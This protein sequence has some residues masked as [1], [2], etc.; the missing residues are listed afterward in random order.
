MRSNNR[1]QYRVFSMSRGMWLWNEEEHPGG[2]S[3]VGDRMKPTPVAV[4]L[5]QYTVIRPEGVRCFAF[6]IGTPVFPTFNPTE[7]NFPMDE[8]RASYSVVSSFPPDVP[9]VTILFNLQRPPIHP[10][11]LGAWYYL[12]PC[13]TDLA[14]EWYFSPGARGQQNETPV[15]WFFLG[16]SFSAGYWFWLPRHPRMYIN[17]SSRFSWA[18]NVP[19]TAY[20]INHLQCQSAID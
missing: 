18:L 13:G 7:R 9:V 8:P 11:T 14:G 15:G 5:D 4:R 10:V 19:T 20:H 2:I 16:G 3:W 6:P 12:P 17:E 1:H